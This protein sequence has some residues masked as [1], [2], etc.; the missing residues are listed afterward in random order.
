MSYAALAACLDR[1]VRRISYKPVDVNEIRRVLVITNRNNPS[2]ESLE[3]LIKIRS[4]LSHYRG[5]HFL[6]FDEMERI[7]KLLPP[8]NREKIVRNG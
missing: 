6:S 7:R 3:A 4:E 2:L 1:F 8:I 5:G